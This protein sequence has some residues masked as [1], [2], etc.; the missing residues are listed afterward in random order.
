ML[1]NPRRCPRSNI[2]SYNYY[3]FKPLERFICDSFTTQTVSVTFKLLN[4]IK[5]LNLKKDTNT[6]RIKRFKWQKL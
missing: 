6:T 1:K 5:H 4:A 2:L 3:L